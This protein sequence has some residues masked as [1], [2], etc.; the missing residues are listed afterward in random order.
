MSRHD[1]SDEIEDNWQNIMWRGRVASAI[2]GKRGQRLLIDL[3]DALD[4][5]PDKRLVRGEI[6]T[7]EGDVCALGAVAAKRGHDFAELDPEECNEV[8]A[9]KL[10]IAECLVQEIEYENDEFYVYGAHA[11]DTGEKR[12]AYMRKWVDQHIEKV[13]D[14]PSAENL[15]RLGAARSTT[16]DA[17]IEAWEAEY[18][19]DAPSAEVA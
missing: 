14:G 13:I 15:K 6:Q 4:S 19:T 18:G 1:Y 16:D 2:R 9:E 17:D 11:R 3:R 8:L 10:D 12:W 5:M 7:A